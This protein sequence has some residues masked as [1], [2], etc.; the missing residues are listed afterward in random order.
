[1]T[2]DRAIF[3][4]GLVRWRRDRAAAA[5]LEHAF[6]AERFAD[7][8]D[9]RLAMVTRTFPR[10]LVLGAGPGLLGRRLCSRPETEL[11]VEMDASAAMLSHCGS[12]RVAADEDALPF[13]P[14]TF[15]LVVGGLTLQWVN[16][17]P[18]ALLQIR[19]I[20]KPDG[21]FLGGLLGG[22]TLTELRQAW[23][24]AE[25]E[26]AGGVSP[27]VAPFADVRDLGGLLQRAGFALPVVDCDT[28]A[29]RYATPLALMTEL[30]A[31]GASNALSDRRRVPVSRHLLMQAATVYAARFGARDGRVPAT[32]EILTL[33]AWAPDASQPQPLRP[34]SATTRLS[35]A[36]GVP[37]HKL[38]DPKR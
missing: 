7:D 17:L 33:T 20:L 4:R 11:L 22:A 13:A 23:L 31:M 1:M 18:G 9:E 28:V 12:L 27:R 14:G 24:E 10:I 37:E 35:D 21:L 8:V 19:Q 30:K 5:A 36:L 29:V 26:I 6:L 38:T 2:D 16:D 25:S 3:D 15:D 32:F 34:G